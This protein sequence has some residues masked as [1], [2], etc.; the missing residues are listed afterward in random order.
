MR[1]KF[2]V[3]YEIARFGVKVIDPSDFGVLLRRFVEADAA[4]QHSARSPSDDDLRIT[5]FVG[6]DAVGDIIRIDHVVEGDGAVDAARVQ[7]H[8]EDVLDIPQFERTGFDI[9][10][11]K[12][13]ETSP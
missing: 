9:R 7:A 1:R 5:S 10:A 6:V 11:V 3:S 13:V 8:L 4:A 2:R 12:V